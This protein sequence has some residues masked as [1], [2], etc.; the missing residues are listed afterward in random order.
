MFVHA[1]EVPP[2]PTDIPIVDQTS[3]L[4]AEQKTNLAGI[5]AAERAS[6]GNQIGILIVQNLEGEPV[7]EYAL[8]VARGWGIGQKDRDSG[9]LLLI[10]KDDRKIRIE[11]GSG[12]EGPLPDIRAGQIIRDRIAPELRAGKYYEGIESGLQG[13]VTA[14]KGE[15][16]PNL[17]TASA[18]R[19]TS[20]PW[21]L[22]FAALFF[23][24][25]WLSAILARTKSWWAG[26]VIGALAGVII[27]TFFGFILIG[28][29][30]IIG[31]GLAG[32]LFDRAVSRNFQKRAR[33]G[34][35]PSWWAGGTFLGGGGSNGSGGFGGFGGGGF[36]GG[37]ASGD[38]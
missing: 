7:E 2:K 3:T 30:S 21:E 10:S 31:L 17:A 38:F 33:N 22:I 25:T 24:P 34:D 5:I 23:I 32:L 1:L 16:D 9:V 37:G 19:V 11:V 4:T 26:G 18:E 35:N 15:V 27:G 12:L 6:S 36:G 29:L 8:D 20:P 13:I 14:I 28:L